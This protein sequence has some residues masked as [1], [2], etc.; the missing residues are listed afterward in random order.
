MRMQHEEFSMS[1]KARH[2]I[3]STTTK[4]RSEYTSLIDA[5]AALQGMLEL[6]A[7]RGF[8]NARN[9]SGRYLSKHPDNPPVMLWIENAEGSIVS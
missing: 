5:V 6:Q 3:I 1:A 4:E 7:A 9:P 2:F 8:E